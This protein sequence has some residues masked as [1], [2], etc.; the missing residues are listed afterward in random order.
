MAMFAWSIQKRLSS[1]ELPKGLRFVSQYEVKYSRAVASLTL[2]I[3]FL[4]AKVMSRAFS[5]SYPI[6]YKAR[7][8]LLGEGST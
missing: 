2:L 4:F 8:I 7:R 5:A 1:K 3:S 6:T